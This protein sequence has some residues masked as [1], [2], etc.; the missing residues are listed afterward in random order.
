MPED[1]AVLAPS[2]AASTLEGWGV[3]APRFDLLGL[4]PLA[5]CVGVVGELGAYVYPR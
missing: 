5:F 1:T 4:S 2:A 3:G